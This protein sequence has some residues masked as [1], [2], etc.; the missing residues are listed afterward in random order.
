MSPPKAYVRSSQIRR[1]GAADV[2]QSE[3]AFFEGRYFDATCQA[4]EVVGRIVYVS[5]APMGGRYPVLKANP[6]SSLAMPAIGIIISKS[7]PMECLVQRFGLVAPGMSFTRNALYY[8]GTDGFPTT[9]RPLFPNI[10]QV[11]GLGLDA[12]RLLL[13]ASVV[14]SAIESRS[15]IGVPLSGVRDGLNRMFTVP[16]Y[17]IDGRIQVFHGGRLLIPGADPSQ[18]EYL[19]RESGGIG[20]G[21]DSIALLTFAPIAR[22]GLYANY[23]AA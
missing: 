10:A 19:T 11:L 21:F 20:T 7:S 2:D 17:F 15:R 22:T 23:D 1:L 13:D 3:A 16:E 14:A 9:T 4:G 5:G 18:G 12:T 8:V 6:A